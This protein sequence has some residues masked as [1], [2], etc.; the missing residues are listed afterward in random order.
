M[1]TTKT[2]PGATLPDGSRV[3]LR[4]IV[5]G[6]ERAT[7]VVLLH[8][9]PETSHAFR[10]QLPALAAAGY[11][12]IAPDLRGYGF[13]SRP[14]GLAHYAIDA[15]VAD[16]AALIDAVGAPAHVVGHDWGGAL[17][18]ELAAAH[19]SKVRTVTVLNCPRAA[20]LSRALTR[21]ADQL[22]RSWYIVAFQVPG[23]GEA[24]LCGLGAR[25]FFAAQGQSGTFTSE[26]IDTYDLAWRQPGAITAMLS[27]Y[28]AS[29]LYPASSRRLRVGPPALLLWGMADAALGE[30]LITPTLETCDDVRLV[31][32]PG[33]SHWSPAEAAEIVNVE[34]L[35]HLEVHG[36]PDPFIYKVLSEGAWSA[37]PD[38]WVGSADDLRDGFVH[39]S[40]GT[41]VRGTIRTHF[42]DAPELVVL[43]VDPA[44]LPPGALRWE[45]SRS[46]KRFPHLYGPL[47]KNAVV[48]V[49][50]IPRGDEGH[51]IPPRFG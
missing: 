8:G 2:Y 24:L 17:A 5:D 38:P 18:W 9:F 33:V 15:L 43:A 39:L 40:A 16:I 34:I 44:R 28:R 22:R 19:P 23:L 41:Q 21:S 20:V 50:R 45:P 14:R 51:A 31:K 42:A 48:D 11:R 30:A 3:M 7:P 6:P 46:G 1:P 4:T 37:L 49:T 10:H 13:S 26:D 32:L 27:Y 29:L 35:S 36:G 47:P 25:R 12:A